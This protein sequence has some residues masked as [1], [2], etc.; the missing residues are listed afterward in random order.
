MNLFEGM[1][2]NPLDRQFSPVPENQGES[3]S[4]ELFF[5]WGYS[6]N[7]SWEELEREFRCVILAEAG[8]GKT[9]EL[10]MSLH[11]LGLFH[12]AHTVGALQFGKTKR[13]TINFSS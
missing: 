4:N 2:K 13:K 1:C 8:A 9:E 5:D 7:K 10:F 12:L 6:N 11:K 3:E